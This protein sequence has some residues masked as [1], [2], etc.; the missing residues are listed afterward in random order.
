MNLLNI[1]VL[2]LSLLMPCAP[3][4][5]VAEPAVKMQEVIQADEAETL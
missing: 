5:Q 2:S 4:D 3:A 1:A